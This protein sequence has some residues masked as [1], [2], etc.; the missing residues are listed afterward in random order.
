MFPTNATVADMAH[1]QQ[2]VVGY[3]HPFDTY[4]DPTKETLTNE[5]PVDVALGKVNY[6]E[7]L[8]F[9]DHKSTARVWYR[10][11]NCGFRLPTAA[12]TD[13]M[14]NFASLRGPVGLNRVYVNVPKGPLHVEPWLENLKRGRTFATNGPLLGFSLG[15][16]QLGDELRLPSGIHEVKFKAWMRSI[17]PVEHLEIICNGKAVRELKLA[18][19]HDRV[20]EEGTLPISSTGW[21]LLRASSDRATF[22]VLDLYPYATTSPIYMSVEGSKI[23]P[24]ED[25]PY[26][27][28]WIDQLSTAA[29]ANGDWNTEAEKTTVLDQLSR[30]RKV[31]EE[32][33]K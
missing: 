25:V 15:D 17:V 1:E 18:A 5:L 29:K 26:F 19:N 6:I 28:A 30:A 4:P 32:L 13:A 12:G 23:H 27:L 7:V 3:V 16:R 9:S 24:T 11:L 21:C 2:G 31:Y 22:P 14:A 20:D 8:G 10:L 33:V